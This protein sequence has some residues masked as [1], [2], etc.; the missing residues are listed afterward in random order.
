MQIN[1]LWVTNALA[2][3]CSIHTS[4]ECKRSFAIICNDTVGVASYFAHKREGINNL[5][6]FLFLPP[7]GLGTGSIREQTYPASLISFP[8]SPPG[9]AAESQ[10]PA[11]PLV[12]FPECIQGIYFPV[13]PIATSKFS[14][15]NCEF[16]AEE[17][18]IS[19]DFRTN[20]KVK[21]R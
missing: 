8:L 1:T 20:K 9:L 21:E 7:H 15:A 19:K 13:A 11:L 17:I 2:P 12:H 10:T 16:H 14:M 3:P 18:Q 5:H 4:L 6:W